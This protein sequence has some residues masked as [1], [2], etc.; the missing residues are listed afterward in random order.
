MGRAIA[1]DATATIGTV[2]KIAENVEI[3]DG[4]VLEIL[5]ILGIVAANIQEVIPALVVGMV[6]ALVAEEAVRVDDV[7]V[8]TI[9][10]ART[11][12][13]TVMDLAYIETQLMDVREEILKNLLLQRQTLCHSPKYFLSLSEK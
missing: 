9:I 13:L 3:M 8:P 10:T 1:I 11:P 2:D 4:A 12:E 7:V 6:A 5:E